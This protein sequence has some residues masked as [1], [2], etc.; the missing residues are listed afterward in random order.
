MKRRDTVYKA[1][2]G[3]GIVALVVPFAVYAAGFSQS[4]VYDPDGGAG[5]PITATFDWNWTIDNT[6]PYNISGNAR[7]DDAYLMRVRATIFLPDEIAL[8][9]TAHT[10]PTG[11]GL[12]EPGQS[13]GDIHAYS[14]F[15]MS[16]GNNC[17]WKWDSWKLNATC[18]HDSTYGGDRGPD[19]QCY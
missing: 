7:P 15:N 8:H 5:P 19:Y 3:V 2:C 10:H 11:S 6:H 12:L 9:H 17:Y 18:G 16:V 13:W 4:V 1:L 14:G